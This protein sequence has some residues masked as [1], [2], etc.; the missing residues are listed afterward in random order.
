MKQ[1]FV[2]YSMSNYPHFSFHYLL[3]FR[4]D[5][6]NN[7]EKIICIGCLLA[8]IFIGCGHN[9]SSEKNKDLTGYKIDYIVSS[10]DGK[11][12]Y[13]VN[14]HDYLSLIRLRGRSPNAKYDSYYVV[15][16]NNEELSFEA[17][18]LR[19]WSSD[20]TSEADFVIV[21]SGMIKE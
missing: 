13:Q 19:F 21:E 2:E 16:T 11:K 8:F 18:D 10:K 14:G 4:G 9:S 1:S 20:L 7:L 12:V 3:N 5:R 15:L 17:V 6:R